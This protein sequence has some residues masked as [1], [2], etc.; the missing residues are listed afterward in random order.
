[1][2]QHW[3]TVSG[4]ITY[5]AVELSCFSMLRDWRS[6]SAA[7]CPP[8]SCSDPP[9][10]HSHTHTDHTVVQLCVLMTGRAN[11]DSSGS[12]LSLRVCESVLRDLFLVS[13]LKQLLTQRQRRRKLQTR[14]VNSEGGIVRKKN[15]KIVEYEYWI[16]DVNYC[17]YLFQ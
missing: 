9:Y 3:T 6:M 4:W 8:L 17:I 2:Y 12:S 5:F 14:S 16:V 15:K 13:A 1:M 7:P 10:T 11:T